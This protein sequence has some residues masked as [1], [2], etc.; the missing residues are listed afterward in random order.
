MQTIS[1]MM[2]S[3]EPWWAVNE[4][5]PLW[6]VI[7]EWL[8]AKE[9]TNRRADYVKQLRWALSRFL[10]GRED[11]DPRLISPADIEAFFL[12][13]GFSIR[14]RATFITRL[15]ALHRP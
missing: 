3:R 4:S 8:L 11:H 9:S 5:P 2:E 6:K 13:C 7:Q 14:T 1:I 10:K 15:G 12:T